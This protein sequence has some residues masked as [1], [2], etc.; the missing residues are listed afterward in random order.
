MLDSL[1]RTK[2]SE[3]AKLN[4]N[5]LSEEQLKKI[6]YEMEQPKGNTISDEYVD[7]KLWVIGHPSRQESFAKYLVKRLPKDK[8]IKILEVGCGRTGRVSRILGEE[9]FIVTGIDPKLEKTNVN[10]I[11]FIK[12]EFDYK[13][14]DLSGYDFVVAQ[15]PCDATEHVVRA[16]V[17]QRVPFIMSLCGVPHKLIS[18]YMPKN[19]KEWYEYL[20]NISNKDLKLRYIELDPLT[21]TPILKSNF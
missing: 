8:K 21:T 19:Y 7:F 15:E 11:S 2:F 5:E 9:G 10:N 17:N 4:P 13:K 3:Y 12:D 16:C 14:F 20:L 18:G 6:K 1:L